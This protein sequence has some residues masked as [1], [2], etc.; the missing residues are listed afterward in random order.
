MGFTRHISDD[1]VSTE[2]LPPLECPEPIVRPKA[3]QKNGLAPGEGVALGFEIE[4]V[5][6][7]LLA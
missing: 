3:P 1:G 5:R 4:D 7:I 2:P 6:Q